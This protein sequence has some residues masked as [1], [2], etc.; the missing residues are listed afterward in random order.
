MNYYVQ[1]LV[2]GVAQGSIYALMAIG[3]AMIMG[4][5][6]L[7]T[8]THGEVIMIGAFAGFYALTFLKTGIFVALVAGFAAAWIL[9]LVIELICYR[10]WPKGPDETWL[11]TTIGVSTVLKSG[12]QI[13]LGTEQQLVPDVY[14][15][16]W[17]L[18]GVRILHIQAF[19][20]VVL[21]ILSAGLWLFLKK[22]RT[23]LELKAVS[24]DKTAAALLG[25]DVRRILV[26]GNA[27]GCALCGVSG[28]L[29]GVYYNSVHAVMGGSAGLK[30]FA[31]AVLGGLT[32]I[33]G[34]A[35]GGI[36]L[37]IFENV[38]VLFFSSG[39]RD[40][41]AFLILIAVLLVRPSGLLGRK[42]AEKV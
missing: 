42:G 15:G 23:G 27:I 22:T 29:L 17:T 3:F 6:G 24:M 37:G 30:S 38:G 12:A 10:R 20:L 40:V 4:I 33:P 11:I 8:F 9:G 34:A 36:L 16:F 7:V 18:G 13:V 2:D 5:L 39:W 25:V 35:I 28:V 21:F 1:T 14:T 31:S 26:I 41:I 32:S 19:M